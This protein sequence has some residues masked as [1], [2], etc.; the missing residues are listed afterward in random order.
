[1]LIYPA[2]ELCA[3]SKTLRRN[4]IEGKSCQILTSGDWYYESRLSTSFPYRMSIENGYDVNPLG[5]DN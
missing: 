3:S 4:L 1:S 5:G 2:K